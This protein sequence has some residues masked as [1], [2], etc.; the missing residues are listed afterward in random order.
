MII[1]FGPEAFSLL[2][3]ILSM[4]VNIALGFSTYFIFLDVKNIILYQDASNVCSDKMYDVSMAIMYLYYV[5]TTIT[6]LFLLG[7]GRFAP[8]LTISM[9]VCLSLM[10]LSE[11]ILRWVY[12][13]T[14][15]EIVLMVA[16]LTLSFSYIIIFCTGK[17]DFKEIV[18]KLVLG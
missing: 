9:A 2:V 7:T 15:S 13:R 3:E 18:L 16:C 14:G 6:A 5:L 10:F 11:K 8:V 12:E 17:E 4:I 1:E